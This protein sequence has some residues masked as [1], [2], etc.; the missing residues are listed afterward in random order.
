MI[1]VTHTDCQ[2]ALLYCMP[3]VFSVFCSCHLRPWLILYVLVTKISNRAPLISWQLC[4]HY[5]SS[6]SIT[7]RELPAPGPAEWFGHF[8]PW[9]WKQSK[10]HA[11]WFARNESSPQV[12]T[13]FTLKN[14]VTWIDAKHQST[15]DIKVLVWL[16]KDALSLSTQSHGLC[17]DFADSPSNHI[18]ISMSGSNGYAFWVHESLSCGLENL[19]L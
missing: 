11:P 1:L 7:A 9:L 10:R 2:H 6:T 18:W 13:F 19:D 15:W 5:L 14:S 12:T 3:F 16:T 17:F 4:I 8:F